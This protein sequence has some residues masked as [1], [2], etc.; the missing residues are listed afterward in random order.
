MR[1]ARAHMAGGFLEQSE[2]GENLAGQ[3]NFFG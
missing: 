1:A 2:L 3:S